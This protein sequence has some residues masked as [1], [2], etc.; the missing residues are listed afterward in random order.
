MCGYY[1]LKLEKYEKCVEHCVQSACSR[2]QVALNGMS[3]ASILISENVL[4]T[5]C[6]NAITQTRAKT[7]PIE[8]LFHVVT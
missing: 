1:E 7:F 6:E 3:L 2:S 5:K 4:S 8:P